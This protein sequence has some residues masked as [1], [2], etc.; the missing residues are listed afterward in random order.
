MSC[1]DGLHTN[2]GESLA[3]DCL[4]VALLCRDLVAVG[5]N[6]TPPKFVK[7]LLQSS[8]YTLFKTAATCY[9]RRGLHCRVTELHHA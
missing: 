8:R 7:Q 5:V 9:L 2:H 1:K 4:P 3:K 6:C